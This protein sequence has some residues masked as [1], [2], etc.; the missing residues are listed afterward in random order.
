MLLSRGIF[1]KAFVEYRNGLAI[2]W[3]SYR[4]KICM[5]LLKMISS[6][7]CVLR[8]LRVCCHY[9]LHFVNSVQEVSGSVIKFFSFEIRWAEM[10]VTRMDTPKSEIRWETGNRGRL[11]VLAVTSTPYCL[12]LVPVWFACG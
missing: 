6:P 5:S 8:N 3:G 11:S 1:N 12:R 10:V 4:K 2:A 7:Y 9:T